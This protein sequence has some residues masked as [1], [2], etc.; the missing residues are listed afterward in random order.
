MVIDGYVTAVNHGGYS[1]KPVPHDVPDIEIQ[2]FKTQ[3]KNIKF[4]NS[5]VSQALIDIQ[6]MYSKDKGKTVNLFFA[7]ITSLSPQA[8]AYLF[9]CHMSFYH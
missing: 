3:F 8:K 7:N 2:R 6:D 1:R 5:G 9:Q 4:Q